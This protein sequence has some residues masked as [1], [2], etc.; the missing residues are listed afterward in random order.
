[1]LESLPSSCKVSFTDAVGVSH[2]V[3]L[4]ASSLYEAAALAVA[5]FK[6]SGFALVEVG[7]GTKLTIAVEAP[8]I[9]H[10]L[11]VGKLE[12]WLSTN[13]KSPREQAIKVELRELLGWVQGGNSEERATPAPRRA[14]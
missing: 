10:E 11:T 1:M 12:T 6:K 2:S 13:G 7:H 4:A 5:E 9:T 8:A 3:T 14:R